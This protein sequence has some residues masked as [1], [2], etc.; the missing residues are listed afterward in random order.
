MTYVVRC[1]AVIH[2]CAAAE[3]Q[4]APTVPRD[5]WPPAPPSPRVT[6]RPGAPRPHVIMHVTDDQGWANVG[7]HNPG[8]VITPTMDR[9]A[10]QEGIRLER[11]YAFQWCAPSRASLLTGRDVY[12]VL[13][14]AGKG[15][16]DLPTAVTRGMTMLPRKLQAVG[17]T[18]HQVGKW[19]KYKV[20]VA[21]WPQNTKISRCFKLT[22][23]CL[24]DLGMAMAWE[25]PHARGFNTSF[26][27][28]GGGEDHY[29][30]A[31][32]KQEWGCQGTDLWNTSQPAIGENG[33]YSGYL[34]N[35]AAVRLIA[36]HPDPDVNPLFIYLATQ[37]MHA[38]VQ[39]PSYYS[40]MYPH[41][42]N[43]PY[44]ETYAIS[45]GMATV[46]DSILRNV[47]IA[48]KKR[49][50][51]QRTLVIHLSDNGGPVWAQMASHANN[52]PHRGGAHQTM[53][54]TRR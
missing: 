2:A 51:W 21:V 30:Q 38:P 8:H 29:T 25:T 14:A 34:Y 31:G 1:L 28:L 42:D 39:V 35:D 44:T 4:P 18:T 36:Q 53:F 37:T 45:N 41:G 9:L 13:G 26:G 11:H 50:M 54:A 32:M 15:P 27:F 23:G 7:Y 52:F 24:A 40:D 48:L 12:H 19:R 16:E 3:V 22:L 17:Y 10:T 5:L 43:Q 20:L 6:P 46:T 49:G 47:S 33:T